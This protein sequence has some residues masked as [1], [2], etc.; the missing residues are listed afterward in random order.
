MQVV[1]DLAC[2]LN[3]L[4]VA[5]VSVGTHND[6]SGNRVF[7]HTRDYEIIGADYDRGFHLAEMHARAAQL[8]RTQAAADDANLSAGQSEARRNRLDMRLAVNIF[9]A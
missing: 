5:Y 2:N 9:L 8:R 3:V 7:W 6:R 1:S 4:R